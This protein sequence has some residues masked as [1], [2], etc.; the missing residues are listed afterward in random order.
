[1]ESGGTLQELPAG[2]AKLYELAAM[3][4]RRAYAPYSSCAVGAA[5]LTRAGGYFS[6]CNV[7][8]S[9][10]SATICAERAAVSAA[11]TAEGEPVITE[12]MVVT[13]AAPPWPPCGVCR[14]VLHEFGS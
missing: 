13:Q 1:M 14:Q 3:A 4:R 2:V 12:V 5:I 9:S 7:E 11:V 10:Y 8:N 6:G